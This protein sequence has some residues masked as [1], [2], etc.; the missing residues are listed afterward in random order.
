MDTRP[1]TS[2]RG[3]DDAPR[4]RSADHWL[5][6]IENGFTMVAALCIFALMFLGIAQVLGRQL[7]DRPVAGYID[8]VELSMATFAFLG[9]AYCQREGGH[10]RM[11]LFVKMARGRLH[12][13]FELFGVVV[14]LVLIGVLIYYGWDHFMR[15]YDS[16]DSTIDMEF[17]VWP[18]KLLV[19]LSFSLLFLRL[20]LQMIGYLRLLRHPKAEPL[21]VPRLLT[22][23]E[24][25]KRE[26]E[27]STGGH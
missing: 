13:L 21:A 7:L 9:I 2:A 27:E 4:L 1:G 23:E 12:W 24:L 20:F 17:P 11:D 8:L 5:A 14:A 26:I 19:P 18:S 6:R 10:V 22:V 25:A 3:R 15:A 16:G